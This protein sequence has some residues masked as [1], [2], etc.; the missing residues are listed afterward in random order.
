MFSFFKKVFIH[1]WNLNPFER[2]ASISYTA[3]FSLGPMILSLIGILG[4]FLGAEMAQT[5]IFEVLQSLLGTLD[6]N[7]HRMISNMMTQ[8]SFLKESRWATLIGVIL[9]FLGSTAF[10]AHLKNILNIIWATPPHASLNNILSFIV[11]RIFSF[12]MVMMLSFLIL[13]S[14][15]LGTLLSLFNTTISHYFSMS[16]LL[17]K[18]GNSLLSFL[19]IGLF[20][21][22]LFQFLPDR[23]SPA[24]LA[25]IKNYKISSWK[26]VL[27]GGFF[28]SLLTMLGRYIISFY[29]NSMHVNDVYGAAGSIVV[30]LLWVYYSSLIFLLGA[31]FTRTLT[32]QRSELLVD[33]IKK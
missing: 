26:D 6:D 33:V 13:I 25:E 5:R 28:T 3:L 24:R 16:P 10:F 20:F 17:F 23:I 11:N 7:A 12:L 30:I 31:V 27:R 14:F 18:W 8:A 15:L 32:L 2:A 19:C 21:T 9:F 4:L 22:F 29:I 1:W